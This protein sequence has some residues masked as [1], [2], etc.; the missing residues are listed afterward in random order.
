MTNLISLII[1]YLEKPVRFDLLDEWISKKYIKI[2]DI[3]CGNHSATRMK[4]YYP[5]CIYY[6]L[7]R[8]QNYNNDAEDFKAMEKCYGIDL[9]CDAGKLKEIPSNFFDCIILSH[10]LEHLINGED[11]LL[12]CL[13]KLKT[14]GVVYVEFPSLRSVHL[15]SMRGTLN[16]YDDSTHKKIYQI[17]KIKNLLNSQGYS[18][19]KSGTRRSPKRIFLLPVYILG[20]LINSRYISGHVFWDILGFSNYIIA[21]KSN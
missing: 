14:G 15:P 8:D 9:S 12:K 13:P 6:G 20:S 19:V 5:N 2:L 1:N 21:Q 11:V 16:F 4:K 7:D 18:I 3:G 10:I 17:K